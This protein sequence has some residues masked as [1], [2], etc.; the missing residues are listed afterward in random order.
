MVQLDS[1]FKYWFLESVYGAGSG[2]SSVEAWYTTALD[3]EEV[4]AGDVDSH[5]HVFVADVVKSCDTVDRGFGS[6]S[7]L[8]WLACLV[9]SMLTL[10]IMR[11]L[12]FDLSLQLALV[13]LGLGMEVFPRVAL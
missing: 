5:V 1:W 11:M 2:R 7:R 4:L 10:S 8:S 13:S 9:S 12:A 6:G 3:I